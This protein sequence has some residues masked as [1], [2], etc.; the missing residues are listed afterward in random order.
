MKLMSDSLQK[1]A[2]HRMRSILANLTSNRFKGIFTGFLVTSVI[3]S[4]SA[5]TVMIVSFVNA[6]LISLI[7]AVS[8]IM[9]ANIGTTITAWLIALLGF[10]VSISTFA[11]AIVGLTFFLL[12]AKNSRMRNI[13]ELIMGFAILFIG[14]ELLKDSVPDINKNP[15]IVE[16]LSSYTNIGYFSILLFVFIGTIL[17]VIIQSSS[18]TMALT[19]VMC[20]NGWIDLPIAAAMVLGENIGTTITANLAAVM[21]N[22][23]AKRAARAHLIFNI[24]GVIWMLILF[25]PVITLLSNWI[26]SM[27]GYDPRITTNAKEVLPL[28][29]ALFHTAFNI[30]NTCLLVGFSPQIAKLAAL[31]VPQKKE[32][33]EDIFKLTYIDKS[34]FGTDELSLIQTQRELT[35]FSKRL[36]RMFGFVNRLVFE[37]HPKDFSALLNRVA[38]YE[39]ITDRMEEE[40]ATYLSHV[41]EGQLSH[42]SAMEARGILNIIDDMES[43]ADVMFK[44]SKIIEDF[45]NMKL[46]FS[47][48]Q[49]QHLAKMK[50]K[51]Q[52]A[53]EIMD[54]NLQNWDKADFIKAVELEQSMNDY[55]NFLREKHVEDLKNKEYKFKV[56]SYYSQLF[57]LYEKI[58]DYVFNVSESI[59]KTKNVEE[60]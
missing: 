15:Q 38:K 10:K 20:Y 49:L 26:K 41:S 55:R 57:S 13:G 23:E 37:Q 42:K 31:M 21:A 28:T 44:I 47:K 4:S 58:G 60:N 25:Y 59:D 18:A 11:I 24:I 39:E 45:D 54:Y 50:N 35:E 19:L 5:T 30:V 16:F 2:G 6:G 46:E 32:D 22:T 17:T 56:G 34:F 51:A 1:V 14:L 7:G 53:L 29:L 43:S 40:I 48:E 9:G 36:I 3:Q 12:F 27:M 33:M 52:Q 8:V